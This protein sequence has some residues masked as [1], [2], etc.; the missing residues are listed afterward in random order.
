MR[1][2][3]FIIL[4]LILSGCSSSVSDSTKEY[5]ESIKKR[6]STKLLDLPEV[7]DW[8]SVYYN[9]NKFRNPFGF[10]G[11]GAFSEFENESANLEI[12]QEEV[13]E[14]ENESNEIIVQERPDK[15]RIKEHLEKYDLSSLKLVGVL[16]K[17]DSNY[18]L[19][20]DKDGLLHRVGV[21]DYLGRDSGR[22][23]VILE[24]KMLLFE[25]IQAEDGS[26]GEQKKEIELSY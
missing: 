16:K 2:Y 9:S 12:V 1:L 26:W 15:G 19:I 25:L 22:V 24:D 8:G 21:G 13:I 5:V 7:N 14:S 11:F 10:L 23:Q 4:G 6:K 20:L 3:F 18:G 17:D